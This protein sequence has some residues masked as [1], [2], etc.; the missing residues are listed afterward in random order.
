MLQLLTR[1]R[2]MRILILSTDAELAL[3]RQYVLQQAGHQAVA[4]ASDKAIERAIEDVQ[5]SAYDVALLCHRLPDGRARE[6]IRRFKQKNGGGKIV[7][8][9]HLYGEWPQIEAD[10]YV[11]G[12]DGPDALTG[13]IAEL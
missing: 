5:P 10:R 8:M 13:V 1:E 11:V 3:L 12:S 6:L 4:P 9:V 7:A 2:Q